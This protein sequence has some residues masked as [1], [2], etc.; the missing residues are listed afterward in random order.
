MATQ[1]KAN[2]NIHT[3]LRDGDGNTKLKNSKREKQV[4]N[5]KQKI[6]NYRSARNVQVL[7]LAWEDID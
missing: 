1:I 7:M 3:M 6:K 2:I 5:M 4:K